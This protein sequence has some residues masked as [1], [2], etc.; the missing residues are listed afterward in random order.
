MRIALREISPATPCGYLN[1]R[2]W[3]MEHMRMESIS[4]AEYQMLMEEGWRHFGHWVFRPVCKTC[5]ACRSVRIP[6]DRFLPNRSQKRIARENRGILEPVFG[7]PALE[8]EDLDLFDRWHAFQSSNKGWPEHE[9]GNFSSFYDTFIDQ[10]FSVEAWHYRLDG[11]LLGLGFVDVLPDALSAIY[12]CYEPVVRD[13][14]PGIWNVLRLIEEARLRKLSHV[15]LGYWV[16]GCKG[17]NYKRNFNP[18]EIR[19]EKGLWV[20]PED[21][22]DPA[23]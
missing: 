11:K 2:D 16:E 10:P 12:F 15:Y 19:N 1:D 14:S 21:W 3:Q 17:M 23:T 7:T 22:S 13:R 18:T 8:E 20:A 9:M 5:R 4:A 6:V